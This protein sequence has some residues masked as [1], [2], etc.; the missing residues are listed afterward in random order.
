MN[1]ILEDDHLLARLREGDRKAF[2][3]I[4]SRYW[5][6]L[7]AISFKRTKNIETSEDI[8]QEVFIGLWCNRE[9]AEI[10][11]LER[12]LAMSV[13]YSGSR[14]I[15]NARRSK[16][17]DI[18]GHED[19]GPSISPVEQFLENRNMLQLLNDETTRLPERCR[20]IFVYSRE[21]GLSIAE[22]AEKLNISPSTVNNQLTKALKHLRKYLFDSRCFLKYF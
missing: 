4:Y 18:D 12:Y 22:I 16:V 20:L 6:K 11:S 3:T 17:I 15:A 21:K 2:D 14:Y 1:E 9:R 5:E 19:L 8:V 10:I 7:F 13:L